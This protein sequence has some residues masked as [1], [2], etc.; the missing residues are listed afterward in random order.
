MDV[1]IYVVKNN[2]IHDLYQDLTDTTH[3]DCI[4]TWD[5]GVAP[6][7]HDTIFENNLCMN[8]ADTGVQMTSNYAPTESEATGNIFSRNAFVN[9][10]LSVFNLTNI[11]DITIENNTF[12]K[13]R[14]GLGGSRG[15]EAYLKLAREFIKNQKD[16]E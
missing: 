13:L 3:I 15:S 2:Y 4:Q 1:K 9:I 11:K 5:D 6:P 7:V 14:T 16:E 8:I 10:G 12:F